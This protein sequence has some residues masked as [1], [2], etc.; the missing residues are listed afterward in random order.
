M[1]I[2]NNLSILAIVACGFALGSFLQ[3]SVVDRSPAAAKLEAPKLPKPWAHNLVGKHNRFAN[4]L[5]S[6][7]NGI[8]DRDDQ[9]MV[10]R[11]H[12]TLLAPISGDLE[13]TWTLP[14]GVNVVEGELSDAISGLQ[15]GQEHTVDLTVVGF[16]KES[17]NRTILFRAD[18]ISTGGRTSG[19]V[20]IA[21][22]NLRLSSDP[23]ALS[24]GMAT[25]NSIRELNADEDK[26]QLIK[27]FRSRNAQ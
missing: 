18:G 1:S 14:A 16:S 10:L 13:Y 2:K 15:P 5:L 20:S 8:A 11:A 3:H 9:E 4:L 24:S 6:P 22:E 7:A 23:A 25:G 12:I 27:R 21:T 26:Y 17:S 19:A